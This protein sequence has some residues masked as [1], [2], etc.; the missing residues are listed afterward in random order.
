MDLGGH[1]PFVVFDD[2]DLDE[3][4][5]G[6]MQS[7]FRNSGQTCV[8]ANRIFVHKTIFLLAYFSSR[9]EVAIFFLSYNLLLPPK[10]ASFH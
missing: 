8:C 9:S 2:A 1:A 7:K 4:V 10:Q 6:A 3:A 5:T